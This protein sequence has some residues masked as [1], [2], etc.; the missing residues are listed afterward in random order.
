MKS[1]LA[2]LSSISVAHAVQLQSESA[3]VARVAVL[4]IEMRARIESDGKVEQMSYDKYACWCEETLGEKA[5]DIRGAKRL[6]KD[7]Q[8][9]IIRLEGELGAHGAEVKQLE[10]DISANV[11]SQ[12]DAT[13]NRRK[14]S[15]EYDSEKTESEQCIGALEE[16]IKVLAGAGTG[17]SFLGTMKQVELLSVVSGIRSAILKVPQSLSVPQDDLVLIRH[18]MESPT[19]YVGRAG[20][21]SA[22]QIALNP[23]GDYA[24]QSTRI[25]GILKGMYDAFAAGLEKSNAE[26]ADSEKAFRAFMETK[27]RELETLEATLATQQGDESRKS[28]DKAQDNELLDNTKVQLDADEKFFETTKAGCQQKARQ[29]S[30]RSRLRS[31]ELVGV[32]QAISILTDEKAMTTFNDATT[33]FVQLAAH[34]NAGQQ[35]IAV[36][37]LTTLARKFRSISLAKIALQMKSSGHFDKVIAS[38]DQMI[39]S[40][41]NEE[42]EDIEHRDRCQ[43]ATKA[44]ANDLEDYGAAEQKSMALGSRKQQEAVNLNG[45]ISNVQSEITSAETEMETL[46]QL[47][48]A[49]VAEARQA[50][51]DDADAVALLEQTME[52]LSAF[53]KKNRLPMALVHVS[54]STGATYTIDKYKAPET[55]WS[56]GNYGG[57]H[58]ETFGVFSIIEML[59]EDF[60][61]EMESMRQDDAA[62][63]EQ[64]EKERQGLEDSLNAHQAMKLSL[65]K[66]LVMAEGEKD[67]ARE[68]QQAA[69]DDGLAE[70]QHSNALVLDC[71]WVETH[72]D[73]RRTKRKNEIQGLVDAK[74]F[75]AGSD[76]NI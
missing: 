25:Q 6:M 19:D 15:A 4:L 10:K 53:Y 63:E 56:D 20:Y 11:E 43:T 58:D 30:T 1:C 31:Q 52:S 66:Q 18:F 26:E 65:E 8:E 71:S 32:G 76:D 14:T 13:A 50:L 2:L 51:K 41:R 61:K 27:K 74:A 72:F 37:Q 57:R 75:L 28:L 24:P 16:A 64:Y 22:S 73:S 38:I 35:M 47:R 9:K 23:F 68:A 62:A 48:N 67:D 39:A 5:S 17:T 40:L 29:W 45:K 12:R 34:K 42:Q 44:S 7:T 70:R 36:A 54:N 21:M 60:K 59:H 49:D 46:L 69:F 55:T 3:P 33:S